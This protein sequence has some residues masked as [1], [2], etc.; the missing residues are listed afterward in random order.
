MFYKKYSILIISVLLSIGDNSKDSIAMVSVLFSMVQLRNSLL[1]IGR[2]ISAS[3]DK[4]NIQ[5]VNFK[6]SQFK[7]MKDVSVKR[8]TADRKFFVRSSILLK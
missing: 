4:L 8:K 7:T 3:I 6:Q 5:L 2:K 1:G